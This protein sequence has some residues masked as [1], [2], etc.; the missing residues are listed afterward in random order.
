M[1]PLQK[2]ADEYVPPSKVKIYCEFDV[3]SSHESDF[4]I[5]VS[6]RQPLANGT[7]YYLPRFEQESLED[8]AKD[9]LISFFP[10]DSSS[11]ELVTVHINNAQLWRSRIDI[12]PENGELIAVKIKK[13]E[14]DVPP[15][16]DRAGG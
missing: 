16:S 6:Y 8:D 1:P 3:E 2:G 9:F 13:G 15:K 14:Q 10:A 5:V 7:F 12:T 11:L 4:S